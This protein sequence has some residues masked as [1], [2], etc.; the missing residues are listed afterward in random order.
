MKKSLSIVLVLLLALLVTGCKE[1]TSTADNFDLSQYED[2]IYFATEDDFSERTGWKYVVTLEVSDGKITYVDWNGANV[3]GGRDKKT[4]DKD[5]DYNMVEFGGAQAEWYEQAEIAEANLLETQNPY[6]V[7]IDEDG[8]TDDLTGVSITVSEFFSL[9]EKALSNGPVGRG[10]YEDG[11][12]YAEEDDY[13]NG[14]KYA[15]DLTVINGYIVAA[16]W[17]GLPEEGDITKKQAAEE[18]TYGMV[19]RGGAQSEWHEQAALAESHLLE[20]QDPTAIALSDSGV[21]DEIT[22]ATI[23]VDVFLELVAEALNN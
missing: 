9:V 4:V 18:G 23:T 16:N 3:N 8:K 19:E 21:A 10:M 20:V 5:G 11:T 2:G 14:Y 22:G 7:T 1:S 17:D 6:A 15:V 12:F 13:H